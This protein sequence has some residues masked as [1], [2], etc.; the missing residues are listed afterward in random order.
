MLRRAA[1]NDAARLALI[2]AAT[3]LESFA[4]DH[5]GDAL[6]DF[7]TNHH[8]VATWAETLAHPGT[9][10]WLVEEA[11]GAPVGY[12]VLADATLPGT[13]SGDA[14]LK[15]IYVLSKWHGTGTGRGLFEAAEQ[16]AH[17]RGADRLVLSVYTRNHRAIAFYE[18]RGFKTIGRATFAEFPE[19]FS[20][21][22]MAKPLGDAA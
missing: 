9:A 6:V 10:V 20:D 3:F 8:S 18:A 19:A 11:A 13:T 2:G 16:E 15:R 4:N 22:V 14:E 5:P 17:R 12:A 1:A 7:T 21:F